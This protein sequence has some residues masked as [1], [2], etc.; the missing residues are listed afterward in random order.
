M[1]SQRLYYDDAYTTRFRARVADLREREGA[2][3]VE[4]EATYFYPEGG[5]QLGDR[6]TLGGAPV[7]DVQAAEDGRVWHRLGGGIRPGGEVEAEVDWARRFDHMQQHTGQHILSAAFERVAAAPT[8]SSTLGEERSVIEVALGGADWRL[9]ERVEEAAN[10]LVWEDRPLV[11]HWVD[12]EGAKRF[13]LR[14]APAVSGRIRVV[15]IPEW[16]ASACGGTHA[17]RTGEVGSIKVLHWEKVRGNLR[18]GFVCGG[19]AL[20]DHAWRTEAM[21]EAA[22]RHTLADRE[23]VPHLERAAG[24]RDELRKGLGALTHRLIEAEA[25]ELAGA[26]SDAGGGPAGVAVFD[27]RRPREEVRLLA[28]K[29]LE[30]G[31]PWVVLGAA[32]PDPLVMAGRAKGP[33]RGGP[34]LRELVA[35]LRER[36]QGLGGGSPDLVQV[37]AADAGRAEEAWRWA[38][39]A[40]RRAVEG[41]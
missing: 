1:A 33:G 11:F 6:G 32:A 27:A 22:R 13:A 18:F 39:E 8:L 41:T 40:V 4:L 5:G 2:T 3:E 36:A 29:A 12:E 9:V 20:R 28:L 25:R 14:K 19:R 38:V 16:D 24:E 7:L 31:A 37:A 23:L 21:V 34:D 15:E 26:R 17:R 35:G 10:R 30:A